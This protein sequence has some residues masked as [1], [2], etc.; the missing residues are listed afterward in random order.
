MLLDT[1]LLLAG[2]GGLVVTGDLVVRG[3]AALAREIGLGTLMIGLTVVA[4]GTSAPE[5]AVNVQA[6]LADS[7]EVSFGNIVGSNA[8]NVGL[9]LGL[10]AVVKSLSIRPSVIRREV[11]MMLL[12]SVAVFVMAHDRWLGAGGGFQNAAGDELWDIIDRGEGIL[13]VLLFGIFCYYTLRDLLNPD[14]SDAYLRELSLEEAPTE[15]LSRLRVTV[16]ILGGLIGLAVG[17]RLTVIGAVGLAESLGVPKEVVGLTIVAI[18]TSL[19]ELVTSLMAV[20]RGHTDLVVGNVVGS[21]IFNL[22]LVLSV[23]VLVR[24]L[25]V[26]LGGQI[27]LLVMLALSLVL[28]PLAVSG[29]NRISGFEG[30]FLLIAYVG[31]LTWRCYGAFAGG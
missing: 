6:A 3:A 8:A 14:E 16:Y 29:Q 22:L 9:I 26:P 11:P 31:Y 13:L 17:G 15:R 25:P 18:G 23:T 30:G 19:P 1:V 10:A 2:L 28:F 24:P 20:R 21:N 12:A 27:D 4:F 5:L 7:G